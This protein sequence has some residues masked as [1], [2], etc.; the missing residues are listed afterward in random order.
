M[1]CA[2]RAGDTPSSSCSPTTVVWPGRRAS[3]SAMPTR[4]TVPDVS[5]PS[6][7]PP[8]ALGRGLALSVAWERLLG[9]QDLEHPR[10]THRTHALQGRPAVGHLHL[11]GVGDLPLGLAFHTVALIRSHRGLSSLRHCVPPFGGRGSG[12]GCTG[13]GAGGSPPGA[14]A[15]WVPQH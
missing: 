5:P 14:P 13:W 9:R 1:V 10:T 2:R 7:E 12:L 15:G 6:E 3:P 8:V 11:L 4:A